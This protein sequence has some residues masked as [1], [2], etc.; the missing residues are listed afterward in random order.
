MGVESATDRATFFDPDEH[1]V[2]ASYTLAAGGAPV[3]VEG[4]LE[5]EYA[6]I[7]VDLEVEMAGSDPMFTCAIAS[8]PA[9]HGA[10]DGLVIDAVNFVAREP[11]PDG[12]GLI[13]IRLQKT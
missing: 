13:T 9:G 12:T 7:G 10:G 11:K 4:I 1:G 3:N 2:T 8:L 5:D 6:A